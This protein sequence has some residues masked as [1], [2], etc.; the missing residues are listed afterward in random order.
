LVSGLV[1]PDHYVINLQQREIITKA[2]GSK[3]VAIYS[4]T[5]GGVHTQE[6]DASSQQ[7]LPDEQIFSLAELGRQIEEI[8][9]FPQDIEWAWDGEQLYILQ[10]RPITSLYPTP[11]NMEPET[12][13]VLLS[14][15]SLQG[16]M[17]P[18][19]PLGQ[20]T[21]RLIFAGGGSIFGYDLTN[22][23]QGVIR[24]AG[25]RL[26]GDITAVIRHPIGV[27]ILPKFL[28][29]VDP[30][31][32]PIIQTFWDDPDLGRG[33]GHLRFSTF[34]R[35]ARFLFPFWKR[36]FGYIRYPDGVADQ[37]HHDSQD[38]IDR[39]SSMKERQDG[40]KP[41]LEDHIDLY[42]QMYYAFP[43][44]VPNIA[45][46]AAAGLIPLFI[47]NRISTHLTGSWDLALEITRG[48]PNNVTTQMDLDL[49]ETARLIR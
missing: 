18:F 34:R 20:D 5:G 45:S 30:S 26:W 31:V 10:S 15:A 42:R 22:E 7:A 4:K 2:F 9:D 33:T 49:W 46:G 11:E 39:L 41:K 36:M 12:L 28:S 14:F 19:T 37:I 44:V 17:E 1:E 32:P 38:E 27:R 40:V 47:L 25:E 24:I 23:N 8:F 21:I 43:Y 6:I 16:I 13:R 3:R 35:L 29:V 48:L